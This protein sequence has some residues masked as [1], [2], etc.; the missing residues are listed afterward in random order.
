MKINP[1]KIFKKKDNVEVVDLRQLHRDTGFF[2]NAT[3]ESDPATETEQENSGLGFIGT[4][5]SASSD[6]STKT[7]TR[8]NM[9]SEK[10]ERFS[11][12][13]DKVLGRMELLERK[14]ERLE[15]RLNVG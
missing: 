15:H 14:I 12:R 4:L 10:I 3:Q 13:I 11:R 6:S 8:T 5:A 1:F 2:S 9:D 7:E